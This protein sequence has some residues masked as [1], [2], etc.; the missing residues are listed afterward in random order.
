MY[1]DSTLN[2]IRTS[3]MGIISNQNISHWNGIVKSAYT[4]FSSGKV[5]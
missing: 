2:A 4:R 3:R 1:T 5:E